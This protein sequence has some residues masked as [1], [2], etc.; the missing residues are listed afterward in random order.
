MNP[1]DAAKKLIPPGKKRPGKKHGGVIQIWVTRACDKSCF[2]CTQGSNLKGPYDFITPEQFAEACMSLKGYFGTVGMFGGN[3]AMH[4]QFETLCEIMREHVPK[5]FRGLW[6]NNLLGKGKA[7]R[8][9]FNPAVS[10]LNVHL[11]AEAFDEFKKQWPESRPFG[12]REDSRHGP[13]FVAVQDVVSDVDDQW[14]LIAGCDINRHWSAMIGVFRGELRGYFCEIAGAHAILHQH[15]PD[16]P[17]LG[18]PV[19]PDWWKR[20]MKDFIAQ[21]ISCCPACGVPLRGYGELAQAKDGV[22]QIS[23]THE[24]VYHPKKQDRK[25][26]V[27]TSL[28]QVCPQSLRK[29]TDYL[30]NARR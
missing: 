1:I 11:D 21:A 12:L 6:C 9:T 30:G 17:D 2:G 20:P 26:E 16:L 8:E 5:K 19:K 13:P 18:L 7:A 23:R 4:P 10:N 3:P 14:K 22:E 15:N 24:S 25:V 29:F 27:V 28:S